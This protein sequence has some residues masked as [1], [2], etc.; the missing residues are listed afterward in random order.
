M[1]RRVPIISLV[2][3]IVVI[4]LRTEVQADDL[5]PQSNRADTS[6]QRFVGQYCLDCHSGKAPA[7]DFDL[8]VL[9]QQ[10]VTHAPEDWEKVVK[11]LRARQMP[12]A[13]AIQPE[14]SERFSALQELEQ[15]LD[16]HAKEHPQPGRTE[17]FRRMTRYEY[18]NAIR[19]LLGVDIDVKALLPADEVSHGFDNVTVG[20]LSPTLLNRYVTA[21][22]KVSRLALGHAPKSPGGKTYRVRPD[23]TQE[24]R[25]PGLPFGTRGGTTVKHMFPVDGVYEI[26]VRLARD[27]NEAVE[28]LHEPHEIEFLL[29]RKKL[30]SF[31][32]TPPN[33]KASGNGYQ[34]ASHATVDRHLVVRVQVSAGI[35]DVAATFLKSSNSLLVRQRQPL[36]V[37]YNMYRHP[38]LTPALYQLSINGPFEVSGSGESSSRRK[39]MTCVPES[40]EDAER[41]A[42]QTISRLLRMAI[43]RPVSEQDL[44]RPLRLFGETYADEGYEAAIEMALSSILVHP[45][46]LFR[47]EE[48][49]DNVSPQ[50]PY[51]ISDLN[52]ASR[53]SYFL[54][55]SLPDDELLTLAENGQLSNPSVLTQQTL[56]MLQDDRAEA[57]IENF[58][59]Q[60][61][62]LRNLESITPDARLYPDFGDNL[63]QAFRQETELCFAEIIREDRS[64]LDLLDADYTYLNERLAKHYGIPHIHGTHFRRVALDEETRRGGLLRH[65][66]ILTVTSYATRTSPVIRGKW[67]LENLLGTPPPPPPPNVS[68][69]QENTVSAKL[70]VRERLAQHRE[71]ATC[72]SCHNLIDPVGFSLE[73]FDAVGRWRELESGRPV[74]ATGGL[75]DGREFVGIEGLEAGLL[76][77]PEVFVGTMTEKML[78]YALGRGIESYD[79]PAIREILRHAAKNNY[80]FSSIVLGIVRSTPFQMRMSP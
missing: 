62:Y 4:S 46:F 24:R 77:M 66:S 52:L 15:E 1:S 40:P 71:D 6:T 17:T 74:D 10:T 13:E 54:W 33:R 55:S 23:V 78:T 11:K 39:I 48:T 42:R 72:A 3:L 69:L 53:L 26:R 25:M 2:L 43:R 63:R 35:H 59:S 80:R 58:A 56:R 60:W 28:G 19:D 37:H 31:T 18:E 32:I 29:D 79:A 51:Q 12:P 45:E 22:Q 16:R 49:P 64:V 21:A 61:L 73:N 57:L 20:E 27:R 8:S 5:K 65:G 44:E 50:T 7:A 30:K 47:I 41:C 67:I 70:P 68:T 75:P 34:Q 14:D 76:E 9:L 38:R 36:N